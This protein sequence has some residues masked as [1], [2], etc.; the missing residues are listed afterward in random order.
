MGSV[1]CWLQACAAASAWL[2]ASETMT[3]VI[4]QAAMFALQHFAVIMCK[5][6]C[7]PGEFLM[8]IM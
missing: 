7:K 2:A 8:N 5:K 4:L 3:S 1:S 6:A